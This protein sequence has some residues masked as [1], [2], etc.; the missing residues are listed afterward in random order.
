MA[1]SAQKPKLIYFSGRG[2][3]E[4]ARLIFADKGVEYIGNYT[5]NIIF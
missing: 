2:L 5:R 3:A 1:T 4:V